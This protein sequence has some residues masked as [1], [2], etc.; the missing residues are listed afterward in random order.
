MKQVEALTSLW[1]YF[2]LTLN[3]NNTKIISYIF[4]VNTS[5][6]RCVIPYNCTKYYAPSIYVTIKNITFSVS[7]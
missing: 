7:N 4:N 2:F 6:N 5:N 3:L 1:V